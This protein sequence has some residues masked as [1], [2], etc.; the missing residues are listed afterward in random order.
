MAIS[1]ERLEQFKDLFKNRYG[2]DINDSFAYEQA[3]K[4][5]IFLR[6]IYRPITKERW[7]EIQEYRA[8]IL[9]DI[10]ARIASGNDEDVI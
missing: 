1:K 3:E 8:K 7:N 6:E 5:L 10:I 9:P 2:R 4:L